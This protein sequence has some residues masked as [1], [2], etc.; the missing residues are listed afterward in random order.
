ML[1]KEFTSFHQ[2]SRFKKQAMYIQREKE[3]EKKKQTMYSNVIKFSDKN[4]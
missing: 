3:K 1:Y 4:N 2:S